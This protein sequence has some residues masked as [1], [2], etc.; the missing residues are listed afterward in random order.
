MGHQQGDELVR[1]SQG[2]HSRPDCAAGLPAH[3]TGGARCRCRSSDRP[4]GCGRCCCCTARL[5]RA[6]D[7]GPDRSALRVAICLLDGPAQIACGTCRSEQSKP[8]SSSSLGC[9]PVLHKQACCC[10]FCCCNSQAQH[11]LHVHRP[12]YDSAAAW[13]P[14]AHRANRLLRPP[15]A[16]ADAA[17]PSGLALGRLAALVAEGASPGGEAAMPC[18][19]LATLRPAMAV[20]P[21][22][23]CCRAVASAGSAASLIPG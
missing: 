19:S 18:S 10:C 9:N 13:P 22:P 6:Q 8:W 3:R 12:Q 2:V 14:H 1:V 21:T 15:L 20:G 17:C 23:Q 4:W 16:G 5:A 11:Q 7:W